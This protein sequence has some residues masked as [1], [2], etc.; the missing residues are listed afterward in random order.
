M[1]RLVRV[2][3]LQAERHPPAGGGGVHRRAPRLGQPQAGAPAGHRVPGHHRHR[4][5]SRRRRRG[6]RGAGDQAHRACH[7]GRAAPRVASSPPPRT[8]CR[9]S[10]PSSRSGPTSRRSAPPSSRTCRTRACRRRSSPQVTA[11]NINSSPVI[12]ASIAATSEDGLDKAAAITKAEIEPAL[13]GIEGVGSVDVTGGEEQQVLITLDPDKL[14]ANGISVGQVTGVLAAN[15]LTFPSG[16]ITTE[17]DKIP[18]STIGRIGGVEEIESM[19]V[20]VANASPIP[21][22]GAPAG[23]GTGAAPAASRQPRSGS[24]RIGQP[25]ASA[26]PAPRLRRTL[27]RA[28]RPRRPPRW[29]PSATSAPS[30][31]PA[32]RRPAMRAR[33]AS[34]RCPSRSRRRRTPTPWPWPTRSRRPSTSSARSTPTT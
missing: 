30:S 1:S 17:T 34:P 22:G 15:N 13:L 6:R 29:S 4:A 33:T 5:A 32:S 31:S 25:A 24:R 8:R 21:G 23:A 10:W 19:V 14:T 3:R 9:W 16:Q 7:L 27:G 26:A 28:R 20:G 18:V 2:R 11:L 12:I